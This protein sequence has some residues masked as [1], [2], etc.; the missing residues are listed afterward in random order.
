MMDKAPLND[1]RLSLKAK[2]LLAYLLSKPPDWR[3]QIDDICKHCRE[4]KSSIRA[5]INELRA[6][7]YAALLKDHGKDG[8]LSGS[9]WAIYEKAQNQS[10]P[11]DSTIK[12]GVPTEIP[13][14]RLSVNRYPNKNKSTNN[15]E[16]TKGEGFFEEMRNFAPD[17]EERPDPAIMHE[18]NLANL[19][20]I[21]VKMGSSFWQEW[22]RRSEMCP[23][24]TGCAIF[25]TQEDLAMAKA[26]MGDPIRNPS[27]RANWYFLSVDL[28]SP[29][30]SPKAGSRGKPLRHD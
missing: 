9:E 21:G 22:V 20:E 5:A 27:G 17:A 2:G 29:F 18:C 23:I 8:Q 19:G 28:D 24:R 11:E 26:K 16:R 3:P 4:G 7:G 1:P 13:K 30:G 6:N 12:S 10:Q 14:T 15:N 25:L